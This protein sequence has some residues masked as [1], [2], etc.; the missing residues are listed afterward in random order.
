[1]PDA[2]F[3]EQMRTKRTLLRKVSIGDAAGWKSFN[4]RIAKRMGAEGLSWPE[5]PSVVYARN[6]I[7]HY[8]AMWANGER[9]VYS[10]LQRETGELIGDFHLKS[11]DRARR[12]AEF[13]HALS[14]AV[15]GTGITYE[16]LD[17]V[18]MA[19]ARRHYTLWCKVEEANIRSWKS[20]ERHKAKFKGV[21]TVT[22][23]GVRKHVRVYE[24]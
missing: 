21:R 3:P 5:V 17:A 10:I 1:M 22:I 8:L 2:L 14:P 9:Y 7:L 23:D 18:R 20:L 16:T 15:W 24:L 19:A 4:N 11:I 12:R 13:G 6:E